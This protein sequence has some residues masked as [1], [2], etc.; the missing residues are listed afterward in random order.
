[1]RPASGANASLSRY[2]ASS[3]RAYGAT[4]GVA[5]H[6]LD[7]RDATPQVFPG[8]NLALPAPITVPAGEGPV[9]ATLKAVVTEVGMLID[10]RQRFKIACSSSGLSVRTTVGGS[11]CAVQLGESGCDNCRRLDLLTEQLITLRLTGSA[12]LAESPSLAGQAAYVAIQI[13]T[14][15]AAVNA[16]GVEAPAAAVARL[17]IYD[18]LGWVQLPETAAPVRLSADGE[19]TLLTICALVRPSDAV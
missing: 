3:V 2:G 6:A 5:C 9:E 19:W 10:G 17:R 7:I 15:P 8:H 1:M 4:Q 11:S 16:G 13:R 18:G 12:N 14:A